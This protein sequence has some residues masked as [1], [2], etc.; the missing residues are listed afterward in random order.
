[1]LPP[2]SDHSVKVFTPTLSVSHQRLTLFRQKTANN[3]EAHNTTAND[4]PA[5]GAPANELPTASTALHAGLTAQHDS[6]EEER[7]WVSNV[8]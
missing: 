7:E 2:T 3:T 5:N 4:L 1:V 6:V 8:V